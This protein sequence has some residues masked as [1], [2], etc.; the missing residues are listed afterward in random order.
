MR[1]ATFSVLTVL[2]AAVVALAV[3]VHADPDAGFSDQLH[4]SGI[5]GPRDY[6]AWLGKIVCE[7]LRDD[8]DTSADKSAHFVLINLPRGST[9]AQSYQFLAAAIGTNCP[10]QV[11]VLTTAAA[12]HQ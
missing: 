8:V 6:H 3:P 10:A 11:P 2:T 5:Y 9:T 1:L 12:R 7:R 4:A